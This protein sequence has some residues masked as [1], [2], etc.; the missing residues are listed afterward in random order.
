MQVKTMVESI[1][2][3]KS[4]KNYTIELEQDAS[5][6]DAV[7]KMQE[8]GL[9][10][11]LTAEEVLRTHILICNSKHIKAEDKLQDGDTL[12]IIKTLLGG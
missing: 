3:P 6:E 4:D 1:I 10:G 12:M 7:R 11:N 5:A 9:T 8:E 2:I